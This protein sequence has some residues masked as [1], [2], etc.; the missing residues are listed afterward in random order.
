MSFL[1]EKFKW[2]ETIEPEC[3]SNK[4]LLNKGDILQR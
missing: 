4:D 3:L 2:P 1:F